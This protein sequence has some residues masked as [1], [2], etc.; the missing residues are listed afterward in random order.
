MAPGGCIAHGDFCTYHHHDHQQRLS[1]LTPCPFPSS[2]SAFL[3]LLLV[4]PGPREPPKLDSFLSM[5]PHAHS[6]LLLPLT[7]WPDSLAPPAQ[8]SSL[9]PVVG[10]RS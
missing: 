5:C 3:S 8:A 10:Q 4:G 1:L 2:C 9:I 6:V 7:L